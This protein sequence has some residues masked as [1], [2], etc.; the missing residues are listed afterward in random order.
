MADKANGSTPQG[1][2]T[3][4]EAVRQA[5][6]TLGKDATRNDLQNFIKDNYGFQMTLGHISNC[7]GEIRKANSH[8]KPA[9]AKPP[10][11]QKE[12]SKQAVPVRQGSDISL[13]DIERVKDLVYWQR[14]TAQGLSL[15]A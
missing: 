12:E 5:L 7:K 11:I 8:R 15:I 3:R 14:L 6:V 13:A 10:T 1:G 2:M 4:I 9:L